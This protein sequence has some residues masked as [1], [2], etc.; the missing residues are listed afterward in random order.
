MRRKTWLPLCLVAV[1][2]AASCGGGSPVSPQD[3]APEVPPAPEGAR[4]FSSDPSRGGGYPHR[5]APG[6]RR[7]D[8]N[9]Y[10][11]CC[12]NHYYDYS[13]GYYGCN[14]GYYVYDGDAC[15]VD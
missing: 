12:H 6:F 10:H 15:D 5:G 1:L 14:Y 2:L 4:V 8:L 13:Y 9:Y 7:W 3:A 11:R